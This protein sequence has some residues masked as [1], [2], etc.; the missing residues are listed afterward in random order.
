MEAGGGGKVEGMERNLGES[1][2]VG[3][4]AVEVGLGAKKGRKID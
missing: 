3:N 1:V 2:K 4:D